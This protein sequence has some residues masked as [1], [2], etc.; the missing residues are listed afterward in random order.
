MAQDALL[1]SFSFTRIETTVRPGKKLRRAGRGSGTYGVLLMRVVF[2]LF[3]TALALC[4]E[5]SAHALSSPFNRT[6]DTRAAE[7]LSNAP[8]AQSVALR[9]TFPRSSLA[10]LVTDDGHL[11]AYDLK[12]GHHA[13]SAEVGGDMITVKTEL[14]PSKEVALRDPLALPFLVRGNSL[15]TRIPSFTHTPVDSVEAAEGLDGLPQSLR[16][17]FFMN[18]S[19]LLRRQTLFLAGTDV[20]VTTSVHV[21]DLDASTGRRVGGRETSSQAFFGT[22]TDRS[23]PRNDSATDSYHVFHNELLPLL[24]IVR[25]NIVL[26]VVRPGEY[27]WSIS[28]SQLRMSPRAVVESSFSPESPAHSVP[29]KWSADPTADDKEQTPRFFSKF[30]RNLFDY[31]DEHTVNVT[32]RRAADEQAK[33]VPSAPSP[34]VVMSSLHRTHTQAA[35]SISRLVG[36]HQLN[37][38][39]VSLRNIHEGTMAWTS[40][41]PR[42]TREAS[43]DR[44]VSTASSSNATSSVIAA[45]VWVSGGDEI[46]R[47]PVLR[48]A[49][50]TVVD[51]PQQTGVSLEVNRNANARQGLQLLTP[52]SLAGALVP[53]THTASHPQP[54]TLMQNDGSVS[55]QCR[56]SSDCSEWTTDDIEADELEETELAAYYHQCAWWEMPTLAWPFL[57][58]RHNGETPPATFQEIK[59]LVPSR[60]EARMSGAYSTDN[61]VVALGNSAAVMKTGLAWRTAAFISF[62]VL[63]LAGSIAFLCAGVP[64]RGQLQRAWAQADRNRD[65]VSHTSSSHQQSTQLVPQDLLSPHGGRGTPFS[66]MLD[67][68]PMDTLGLGNVP[69]APLSM[70]TV[71]LPQSDDSFQELMR[72]HQLGHL[73]RSP[74]RSPWVFPTPEQTH[75]LVYGESVKMLPVPITSSKADDETTQSRTLQKTE[76]CEMP[77]VKAASSSSRTSDS[78][79]ADNPVASASDNS[80]DDDTVDIDLGERWWV[81]AQLPPGQL[82]SAP[83]L[84]EAF[85]DRGSSFSRSQA[86]RGTE[87]EEGKLF[88]L[89][90]KVLE[91]V[92]SGGEGSVFCVEHR[93]THARYA[94]KAI[95][96]HERDEERVVQEAVLH[97]SFDNANVV[98]FYFCWIEDIAVSTANRLELCNRDEDGFDAASLAYSDNSLM[99]STSGNTNGRSTDHGT[100]SKA[101]DTYH[102]LFIQ[103]EYFPRGTLADWLRLRTGFFRLEV[104]RYMKQIGDGLAYLHNQDVVHHDLKP[105][106]IFVSNDNILKIG[107]FGLAKRRGNANASF[108]DLSSNVA[109]GQQERSVVGGSPLYSSP[110]QTRGE[111]VNKPS[112]IFSL[113]II[114]VEMLCTFTTLH[115]RIRI[116]TDAHHLILPEE[117]EADFPD[118]AQLIKSMLAAN[119][120]Q[121]PPIRRLLR[122]INKLIVSLEAQESDEEVDKLQSSAPLNG[123]E[124]SESR[125]VNHGA[126]TAAVVQGNASAVATATETGKAD[127]TSLGTRVAG[128][129]L[130]ARRSVAIDLAHSGHLSPSVD[131]RDSFSAPVGVQKSRGDLLPVVHSEAAAGISIAAASSAVAATLAHENITAS[132]GKRGTRRSDSLASLHATTIVKRGNTYHRRC[133]GSVSPSMETEI[134]GLQISEVIASGPASRQDILANDPYGLPT[135]PVLYTEDADLS[136]ILKRDLQ[137]RTVDA[138][139]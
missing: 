75:S 23:P 33:P 48:S 37:A 40:L 17:Y 35:H 21:T 122:Q 12:H 74:P 88:Q 2:F 44:T 36:V 64:P 67:T 52:A 139:D 120:L 66:L 3:W 130:P 13:W 26:H 18:I 28:L 39:H 102:M 111:P 7:T 73:S 124:H 136:T 15:F 42:V 123:A 54:L 83:T 94:I 113:G 93:V 32:Y 45:Y 20:Y 55:G 4:S 133:R 119:P 68:F 89:H 90:F 76:V 85:S 105:T 58:G 81:R 5:C 63:C 72:H 56:D 25:Y 82:A 70:S 135:A 51:G 116:L 34:K 92:G 8:S 96:I 16:P 97:S 84:D 129:S 100:D 49:F 41:L 60:T 128:A 103:M 30:M 50:V 86:N 132:L 22:N 80:S 79:A 117:L 69:T 11:H 24:H 110:E 77:N 108:S 47:I 125:S 10:L 91:K 107:D 87:E 114:A 101:G 9:Y 99:M 27:S 127:S 98:R 31:D 29:N 104:L 14:P 61:S 115:E 106:N 46:F 65:R 1:Q 19:T 112:D 59:S 95:H 71:P 137:D 109:G 134:S 6:E 121:R 57:G 62:H 38:S 138:P 78:A 43:V 118:E 126:V 131:I 53:T